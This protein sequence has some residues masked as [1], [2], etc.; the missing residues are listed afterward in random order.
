M[1]GDKTY[2]CGPLGQVCITNFGDVPLREDVWADE[3]DKW[4]QVS[5]QEY[6][7]LYVEAYNNAINTTFHC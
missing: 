3:K 4:H 1:N 7:R 6:E 5:E 2:W